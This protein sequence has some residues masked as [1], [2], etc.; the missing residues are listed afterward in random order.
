MDRNHIFFQA[1]PHH[2][3]HFCHTYQDHVFFR[4]VIVPYSDFTQIP[5][6]RDRDQGRPFLCCA[7][8]DSKI[9]DPSAGG[10]LS[11]S[12]DCK[13]LRWDPTSVSSHFVFSIGCV[14]GG[15][16]SSCP[17]MHSGW[18]HLCDHALSRGSG[19]GTGCCWKQEAP[20][21]PIFTCEASPWPNQSHP[22]NTDTQRVMPACRVDLGQKAGPAGGLQCAFNLFN[23][24]QTDVINTTFP[25]SFGTTSEPQPSSAGDGPVTLGWG[26]EA[27]RLWDHC[28]EFCPN[29]YMPSWSQQDTINLQR[30]KKGAP[31]GA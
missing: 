5:A 24:W 27:L 31:S 23:H 8:S 26:C 28:C 15:S 4:T 13:A 11:S 1:L 16:W 7:N 6:C 21:S 19:S 14:Q 20:T 17:T 30:K 10:F 9:P 22:G 3:S 25:I 2:C 29:L 12:R 18:F